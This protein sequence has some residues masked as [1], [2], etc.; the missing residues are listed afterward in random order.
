[1]DIGCCMP[2]MCFFQYCKK[3]MHLALI[4]LSQFSI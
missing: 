2:G 4:T 3:L 1:M